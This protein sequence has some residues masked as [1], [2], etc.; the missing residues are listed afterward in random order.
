MRVCVCCAQVLRKK[1]VQ[2]NVCCF[3]FLFYFFFIFLCIFKFSLMN[4]Y[5]SHNNRCYCKNSVIDL[6]IQQNFSSTYYV[7]SNILDSEDTVMKKSTGRFF[8]RHRP[9]VHLIL[10]NCFMHQLCL[11]NEIVNFSRE[12]T[13][14]FSSLQPCIALQTLHTHGRN[15]VMHVTSTPGD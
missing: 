1:E 10:L 15:S 11:H 14:W 3:F 5:Y 12:R 8:S 2:Q 6:C 13:L 7:P 9:A 4:M